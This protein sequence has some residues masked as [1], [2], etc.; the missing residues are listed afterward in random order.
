[1]TIRPTHPDGTPLTIREQLER[2]AGK[3]AKR[4]AKAETLWPKKVKRTKSVS[5]SKLE[6]ALWDVF[7]FFIRT[8]DKRANAG[9]CFYCETNPIDCAMHRVKRGKRAVKYDERNVHGGCHTCNFEDN[10]NPQKFDVIFIKKL[11]ADLLIELVTTG[12][13]E[14]KRTRA[15]I[16]EMTALYREKTKN[17]LTS[18]CG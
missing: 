17:L 13:T 11:G 5:I 9:L 1:M 4:A 2:A 10:Y 3:K 15:G 14:S 6:A 16:L 8:R 18:N 7:S 12:A